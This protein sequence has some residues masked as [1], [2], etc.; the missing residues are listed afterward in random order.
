MRHFTAFEMGKSQMKIWAPTGNQIQ[1]NEDLEEKVWNQRFWIDYHN[2][3]DPVKKEAMFKNWEDPM[4]QN[5]IK[6]VGGGTP[7]IY[8]LVYGEGGQQV[9]QILVADDKPKMTRDWGIIIAVEAK[10]RSD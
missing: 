8:D 5:P 1:Q 10:Q 7:D 2:E 4:P 9:I 6:V 3:S